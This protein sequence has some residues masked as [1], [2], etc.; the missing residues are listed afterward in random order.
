MYSTDRPK[1]Q[2]ITKFESESVADG[3]SKEICI[4]CMNEMDPCFDLRG[5]RHEW[6]TKILDFFFF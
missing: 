4:I 3:H 2:K 6:H 5:Q 1:M